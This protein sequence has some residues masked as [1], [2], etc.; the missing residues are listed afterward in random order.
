MVKK[1]LYI[2]SNL[3]SLVLGMIFCFMTYGLIGIPIAIVTQILLGLLL[4]L[5]FIPVV[6]VFIFVWLA[7][8]NVLPWVVS[9]FG[10]EWAWSLTAMF[11]FNLIVSI[12][13]TFQAVIRIFTVYWR[14]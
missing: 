12:G 6:G 11:V 14:F 8:F 10:V 9:V 1:K 2:A 7:W 4:L 3:I 5:G 13:C